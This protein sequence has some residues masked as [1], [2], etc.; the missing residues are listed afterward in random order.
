MLRIVLWLYTFVSSI[1]SKCFSY[2]GHML[3]VFYLDVAYVV[4]YIY[5]CYK[6]MF[7]MFHLFQMYVVAS[8]SYCPRGRRRSPCV[9]EKR[10]RCGRYPCSGAGEQAGRQASEQAGRLACS[11]VNGQ[12]GQVSSRGRPSGHPGASSTIIKKCR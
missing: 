8:S 11:A 5:I 2:L 10:D 6:R 12:A 3:Y 7:Y 4:V 1:C 9:H